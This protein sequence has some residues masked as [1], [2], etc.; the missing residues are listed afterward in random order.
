MYDSAS[1]TIV[2]YVSAP[3]AS[4]VMPPVFRIDVSIFAISFFDRS[5]EIANRLSPRCIDFITRLLAVYIT[6]GLCGDRKHG[7]VQVQRSESSAEWVFCRVRSSA[8]RRSR[9]RL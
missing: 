3:V 4:S 2:P 6:C 8:L 5:G 9:S 7:V 1:D